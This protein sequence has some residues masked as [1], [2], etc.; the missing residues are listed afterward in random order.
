[1]TLFALTHQQKEYLLE[2]LFDYE[3]L[4]RKGKFQPIS[5]I[6]LIGT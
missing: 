3:A 4:K 5:C 1:M 6:M 2:N